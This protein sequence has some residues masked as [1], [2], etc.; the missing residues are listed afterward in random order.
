MDDNYRNEKNGWNF[1]SE[2]KGQMNWGE[3]Q[4][5]SKTKNLDKIPWQ[6]ATYRD[7][8]IDVKILTIDFARLKKLFDFHEF[9]A[10]IYIHAPCFSGQLEISFLTFVL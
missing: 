9:S 5:K 10:Y 2:R 7:V 8:Y 1:D 4:I 6:C 3:K